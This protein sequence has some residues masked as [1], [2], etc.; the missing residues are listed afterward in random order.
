M[1]PK[2][3]YSKAFCKAISNAL[4][5]VDKPIIVLY[6]DTQIINLDSLSSLVVD[7]KSFTSTG[8]EGIFNKSW[9]SSFFASLSTTSSAS[10]VSYAQFS[11]VTKFIS[12]D[13]FKDRVII[14]EDN[15]RRLFPL[16]VDD[17]IDDTHETDDF[18]IEIPYYQVEQ[19]HID[20]EF[21][22]VAKSPSK[23]FGS[24]IPV[25]SDELDLES[26]PTSSEN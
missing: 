25:F 11:Y 15:L 2:E 23:D 9:F 14:L 1:T 16:N 20:N 22:Y 8:G 12:A 10:I 5:T 13:F 19:L 4:S 21:Y 26:A 7:E 3:A 24:L 17:F 6:G 18:A